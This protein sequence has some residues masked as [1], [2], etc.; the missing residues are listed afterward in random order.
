M[1]LFFLVNGRLP[2][3]FLNG[4]RPQLLDWNGRQGLSFWKWK[5]TI[6]FMLIEE[7]YKMDMASMLLSL[8]EMNS[9]Y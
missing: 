4:R 2:E 5:M 9:F 8:W 7:I 6:K 1:T 3:I